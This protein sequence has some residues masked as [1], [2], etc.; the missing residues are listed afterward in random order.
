MFYSPDCLQEFEDP[1]TP[2]TQ[3]DPI[4]LNEYR[5]NKLMRL[6]EML[7]NKR[8]P[9][10]DDLEENWWI[11]DAFDKFKTTMCIAGLMLKVVN[12]VSC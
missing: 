5:R 12:T 11:L 4:P 10:E 2:L 9:F 6:S 8:S 1:K 3:K 7:R